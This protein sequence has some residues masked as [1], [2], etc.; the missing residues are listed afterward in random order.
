MTLP[1]KEPQLA[2]LVATAPDGDQWFHEQKFDGYRIVAERS[3]H[4]VHLYTRRFNDWTASYPAVAAAVA[5]LADTR[6]VLDGEVAV[7]LADGRTSFQA[8]QNASAAVTYFIFDVLETDAGDLTRRP[9]EERKAILRALLAKTP[10]EPTLV[11][12]DHVVGR[13][14]D[15][16]RAACKSGLEGIVSK[17]RDSPYTAGRSGGWVKT[18][19]VRRQE[20]VIGGWTEPDGSRAGLGALLVGYYDGG[21]LVYAGK[22]GTGFTARAL[23]EVR[24]KLDEL[25]TAKTPFEPAPQRAWT[26]PRV[27]WV[28]PTLVAEVAFAEWTADGR[29]RHPSFKGL[30]ADKRARDVVREVSAAPGA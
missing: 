4:D 7:V 15:F 20:L 3:G 1:I 8:L 29:L 26:G 9:L 18:K 28:E 24:A 16:F 10:R 14:G 27:R 6:L 23:T 2:T 25:A 5:R 12:S 17:R 22:V 13:G 19:C 21:R 11:F 30:R